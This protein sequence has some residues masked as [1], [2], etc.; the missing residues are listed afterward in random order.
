MF[1]LVN[2]RMQ[3][4]SEMAIFAEVVERGSFTEAAERLGVSKGF[5]SK[6]ISALER[7]LEVQLLRRTTRRLYLTEEGRIFQD[8][9]RRTV[10]IAR[11]GMA[12]LHS[13]AHEIS[14]PLRIT[15]PI[16]FGQTFLPALVEDFAQIYPE[17]RLD[18]WLDNRHVDLATDN[19]DVAFRITESPPQTLALTSLGVME[20][21]ICAAPSYLERCGRPETPTDLQKHE[22]LIYLNPHRFRRW[23]FRHQRRIEVVEVDGRLAFNQHN[24]LLAPLLGGFGIAK[25]PGYFVSRYLAQGDLVRLLP[26][27]Q[28]DQLPIYL[29]HHEL[30]TQP[31]RVRA[32]VRFVQE[33]G[34]LTDRALW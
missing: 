6:Q 23:T 33:R 5:V 11:E 15:A 13:R 2:N 14:G 3:E 34:N 30:A 20:D 1:S 24:A 10:D 25:L 12:L 22:C 26:E 27:F 17:V 19:V 18:L 29:V 4:L 8:Y 28:T 7:R 9:C 32:F 16:S 21:I 31:P